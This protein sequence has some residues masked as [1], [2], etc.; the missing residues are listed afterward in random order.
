MLLV[1]HKLGHQPTTSSC[2][3]HRSR[4][5]AE[6]TTCLQT[7]KKHKGTARLARCAHPSPSGSRHCRTLTTKPVTTLN[8]LSSCAPHSLLFPCLHA[9]QQQSTTAKATKQQSATAPPSPTSTAQPPHPTLPPQRSA[10]TRVSAYSATRE[11][12]A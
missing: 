7:S 4:P 2:S 1:S 9:P 5:H 11:I 3:I 12:G 8:V 10:R 6:P